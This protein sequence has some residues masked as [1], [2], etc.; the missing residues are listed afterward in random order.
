MKKSYLLAI[1][2]LVI[3]CNLSYGQSTTSGLSETS[4]ATAFSQNNE[5]SLEE[6]LAGT[7]HIITENTKIT[8]VFT[9]E[10]LK[11]IEKRRDDYQD[12]Y[13][14]LSKNTTIKILPRS[15]ISD[16]NFDPKKY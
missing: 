9:T 15:V 7:Y 8:E 5:K 6:R 14:E 16:P 13:Y 1:P 10:I 12:V 3:I 4:K 11:E 2:A